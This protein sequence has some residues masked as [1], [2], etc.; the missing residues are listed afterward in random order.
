[1]NAAEVSVET[2]SVGTISQNTPATRKLV[3]RVNRPD[4]YAPNEHEI[5]LALTRALEQMTPVGQTMS[6]RGRKA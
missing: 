2:H 1:M 3:I 5:A 6:L 4:G